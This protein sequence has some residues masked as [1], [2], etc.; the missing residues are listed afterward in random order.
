[1]LFPSDN[2]PIIHDWWSQLKPTSQ[3]KKSQGSHQDSHFS[4]SITHSM[5][6]QKHIITV[7]LFGGLTDGQGFLSS[8]NQVA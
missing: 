6:T 4:G 8:N 5:V 3:M 7:L 1:M 2:N